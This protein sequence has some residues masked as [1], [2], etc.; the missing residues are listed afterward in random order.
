MYLYR[1]SS[2]CTYLCLDAYIN[3]YIY[4]LCTQS[5][6][7]L[8][9]HL[10]D[11]AAEAQSMQLPRPSRIQYQRPGC[12][13]AVSGQ[14]YSTFSWIT[15]VYTEQHIDANIYRHV[16]VYICIYVY[17]RICIYLYIRIYIHFCRCLSCSPR[18]IYELQTHD[19][20]AKP[21]TPPVLGCRI[22][23][24]RCRLPLE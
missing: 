17:I 21:C 6:Y 10:L 24:E 19:V 4:R 13:S 9:G 15:Y 12:I 16:Y 14:T 18:S 7:L 5:L 20:L 23:G 2:R 11:K 8:R 3:I 22:H 1:G